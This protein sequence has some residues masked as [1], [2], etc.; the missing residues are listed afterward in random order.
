MIKTV[1]A[2]FLVLGLSGAAVA[3]DAHRHHGSGDDQFPGTDP[4][5]DQTVT[6]SI[7]QPYITRIV[8]SNGP[9]DPYDM[10]PCASNIPDPY[11]N[12]FS[13]QSDHY[14]GK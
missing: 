10:G 7:D 8:P 5:F 6:G 4:G 12:G 2:A 9:Y 14:C 1:L 11:G 3:R 13:G